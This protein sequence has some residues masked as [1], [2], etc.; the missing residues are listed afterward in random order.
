MM[1]VTT[2]QND[3]VPY[4]HIQ[5]RTCRSKSFFCLERMY[6]F[7]ALLF[8]TYKFDPPHYSFFFLTTIVTEVVAPAGT[9]ANA[10]RPKIIVS[11]SKTLLKIFLKEITD[12]H[13]YRFRL[14]SHSHARHIFL[15]RYPDCRSYVRQ[16][17]YSYR[18]R[19]PLVQVCA[20][21]HILSSYGSFRMH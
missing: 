3:V 21:C 1:S 18:I 19:L 12:V 6:K 9:A 8:L 7:N 13:P 5:K 16:D 17:L 10:K 20:C 2:L 11:V 14:G 4:G 15:P